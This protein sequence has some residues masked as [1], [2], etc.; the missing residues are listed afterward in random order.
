MTGVSSSHVDSSTNVSLT[1]VAV[2]VEDR[3]LFYISSAVDFEELPTDSEDVKD[4]DYQAG[5]PEDLSQAE[6]KRR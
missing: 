5:H 6:K 4:K 1:W 2:L 3:F